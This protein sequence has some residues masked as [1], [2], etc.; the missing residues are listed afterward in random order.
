MRGQ[1]IVSKVFVWQTDDVSDQKL[2]Q[3]VLLCDGLSDGSVLTCTEHLRRWD[4]RLEEMI[5]LAEKPLERYRVTIGNGNLYVEV[6]A[7]AEAA[8]TEDSG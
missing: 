4:V 8:A 2:N 3:N 7:D 6:P 1:R 5:G